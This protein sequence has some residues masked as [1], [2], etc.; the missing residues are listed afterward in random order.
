MEN[1]ELPSNAQREKIDA[2]TCEYFNSFLA[3]TSCSTGHKK[4][5]QIASKTVLLSDNYSVDFNLVNG[6]DEAGPYLDVILFDDGEEVQTLPPD[7][8]QLEGTYKFYDS[9]EKRELTL[10][11]ERENNPLMILNDGSTFGSTEG[12]LVLS[13]E[14]TLPDEITAELEDGRI[15]ELFYAVEEGAVKGSIIPVKDLLRLRELVGELK[16][17]DVKNPAKIQEFLD[18]AGNLDLWD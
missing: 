3:M 10:V 14:G 12:C 13:F 1:K 17:E 8:T 9:V 4:N 6:D 7:R 5:Y 16:S 2:A 11:I 18:A 15:Q